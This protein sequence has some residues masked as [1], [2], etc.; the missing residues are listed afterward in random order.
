MRTRSRDGDVIDILM[1]LDFKSS[2]K[3]KKIYKNHRRID[4]ASMLAANRIPSEA[5]LTWSDEESQDGSRGR[6]VERTNLESSDWL[7]S[8]SLGD[9]GSEIGGDS[10]AAE[11]ERGQRN[12]ERKRKKDE[13]DGKSSVLDDLARSSTE[14]SSDVRDESSLR[15]VVVDSLPKLSRLLKVEFRDFGKLDRGGSEEL[16]VVGGGVGGLLVGERLDGGLVVGSRSLAD[17]RSGSG[18]LEVGDGV[19]RR[20]DRELGVV[21]TESVSLGIGVLRG[22]VSQNEN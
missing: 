15:S 7:G 1:R 5:G 13:Q 8:D 10:R 20:V 12:V 14:M 3:E 4:Q 2:D 18:S 17:E 19:D 22:R 16:L 11:R 21:D 9:S 6:K